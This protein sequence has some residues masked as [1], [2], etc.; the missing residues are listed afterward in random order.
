VKEKKYPQ[1]Q[2]MNEMGFMDNKLNLAVL[3]ENNFHVD[4][5]IQALLDKRF[6]YQLNKY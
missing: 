1:L 5:A 6:N 3:R 4:D 2:T